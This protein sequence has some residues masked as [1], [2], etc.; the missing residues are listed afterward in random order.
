MTWYKLKKDRQSKS[1][2]DKK[3]CGPKK[4]KGSKMS[5]DTPLTLD[6]LRLQ[7]EEKKKEDGESNNTDTAETH[8]VVKNQDKETKVGGD[9][10]VLINIQFSDIISPTNTYLPMESELGNLEPVV[11]VKTKTTVWKCIAHMSEGSVRQNFIDYVHS[12]SK[13]ETGEVKL[14]EYLD[15]SRDAQIRV[16]TDGYEVAVGIPF[17]FVLLVINFMTFLYIGDTSYERADEQTKRV[18]SSLRASRIDVCRKCDV[19]RMTRKEFQSF[20]T[21]FVSTEEAVIGIMS[22][23]DSND[24][25]TKKL[26]ESLMFESIA[27]RMYLSEKKIFS[28]FITASDEA[29]S[30]STVESKPILSRLASSGG[31]QEKGKGKEKEGE[32]EKNKS[33]KIHIKSH[34]LWRL[35]EKLEKI[36]ELY[37]TNQPFEN[38]LRKSLQQVGVVGH[39][40]ESCLSSGGQGLLHIDPESRR[41]QIISQLCCCI[42]LSLTLEPIIQPDSTEVSMTISIIKSLMVSMSSKIRTEEEVRDKELTRESDEKEE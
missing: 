20:L 1:G 8:E 10:G 42:L 3:V 17:E 28:P 37:G 12:Q 29:A 21:S 5:Q 26:I 33:D 16:T 7:N 15:I 31:E 24:L 36:M 25:V 9:D 11:M 4:S 38:E 32:E 23:Y 39:S 34:F 40:T 18:I 13:F 35:F 2:E 6:H 41:D 30:L 19:E 14:I 22:C 27:G